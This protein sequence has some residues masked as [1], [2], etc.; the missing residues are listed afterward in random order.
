MNHRNSSNRTQQDRSQA[1]QLSRNTQQQRANLS[2]LLAWATVLVT[3]VATATSLTIATTAVATT[4]T[5]AIT[6]T[7]TSA[8]V[9]TVSTAATNLVETIT[10]L[11]WLSG[12]IWLLIGP[13]LGVGHSGWSSLDT[14]LSLGG[15]AWHADIDPLVLR[16]GEIVVT[17]PVVLR[18]GVGTVAESRV[19]WVAGAWG[20]L[21]IAL[22]DE[23]GGWGIVE[24]GETGVGDSW[25][26]TNWVGGDLLV[27]NLVRLLNSD[28]GWNLVSCWDEG[29][30]SIL[31]LAV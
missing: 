24:L 12:S 13:A 29:I 15:V 3:A 17:V 5:V 22:C 8:T 4:S 19:L 14:S 6:T 26:G 16:G 28:F 23:N 21:S 27:L 1:Q 9:V 20:T 30:G 7:T 10:L 2:L 11:L 31:D 18:G 25:V